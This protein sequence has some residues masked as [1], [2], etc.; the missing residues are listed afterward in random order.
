MKII[1]RFVS[2]PQLLRGGA[3]MSYTPGLHW[4]AAGGVLA[5]VTNDEEDPASVY[6]FPNS[7]LWH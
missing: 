7:E 4:T 3:G 2:I 5:A 6:P 1:R